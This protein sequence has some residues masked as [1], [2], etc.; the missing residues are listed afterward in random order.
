MTDAQQTDTPINMVRSP[1]VSK[2]ELTK[3][4]LGDLARPFAIISTS[5][6]ATF[7]TIT[8]A[9]RD[10]V[11]LNAAAVFMGAVFLGVG[12][13][14]GAKSLENANVSKHQAQAQTEVAKAQAG[15]GQ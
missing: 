7:A 13:L 1:P 15:A 2:M 10:G 11:E 6:G 4:F 3:A 9:L 5:A 12:T 8:L 14:Y